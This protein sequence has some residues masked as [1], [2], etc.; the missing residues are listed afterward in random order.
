MSVSAATAA[1][2]AASYICCYGETATTPGTVEG[3]TTV[4]AV[5]ALATAAI[6]VLIAGSTVAA[7][8]LA[9]AANEFCAAVRAV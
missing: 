8:G 1:G 6:Q 7:K 4:E 3:V 2:F 9:G 5:A